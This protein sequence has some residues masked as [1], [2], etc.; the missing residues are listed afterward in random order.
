MTMRRRR[1]QLLTRVKVG[2]RGERREQKRD[3]ITVAALVKIR[4]SLGA[5]SWCMAN[6]TPKQ[7]IGGINL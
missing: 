4:L 6:I 7:M 2:T 1:F 3:F 5:A